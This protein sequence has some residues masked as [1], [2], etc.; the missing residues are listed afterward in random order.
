MILSFLLVLASPC[1]QDTDCSD[2]QRCVASSCQP[3][4]AA[5]LSKTFDSKA[6]T[7]PERE[8]V[9][10]RAQSVDTQRYELT[11]ANGS[12]LVGRLLPSTDP[13]KVRIQLIDGTFRTLFW[14]DIVRK[15]AFEGVKVG[16]DGNIWEDNP[17]RTRH[18]YAPSAMPLQKGEGY[19]SL[20]EFLF[21]S[22]AYGITDNVSILVGSFLPTLFA[23][24]DMGGLIGAIKIGGEVGDNTYIAGGAEVITLPG[25]NSFDVFGIGFGAITFGQ[26]DKQLTLSAGR[27]FALSTSPG[28]NDLGDLLFVAAGQLRVSD[29]YGVVTE[30]WIFPT[31]DG[32]EGGF[33]R[34]HS[35]VVRKMGE[36]SA[37]DF[38]FIGVGGIPVLIPWVDWT[39]NLGKARR[40]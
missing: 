3:V 35:L 2:G 29:T 17:N 14:Q 31:A 37:F 36:Q 39:W 9:A 33:L 25:S 21:G 5:Q 27:P 11:L 26:P 23:G 19:V 7:L 22:A 15:R 6:E 4:A 18:I 12:V 34:L 1:T 13:E 16:A 38:G 40:R 20:K 30:N 10:S 28:S 8:R 24:L 32:P